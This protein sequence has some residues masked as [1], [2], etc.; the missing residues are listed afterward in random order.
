MI[1]GREEEHV[2]GFKKSFLPFLENILDDQ[3]FKPISEIC[4]LEI[5]LKAAVLVAV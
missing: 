1:D 3:F 2:L 4:R 5:V